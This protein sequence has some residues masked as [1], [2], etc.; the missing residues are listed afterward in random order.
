MVVRTSFAM[1]L[2]LGSLAAFA[3]DRTDGVASQQPVTQSAPTA[4]QP[5]TIDE[6]LTGASQYVIFPLAPAW[7]LRETWLGQNC[8][9]IDMKL[10]RLHRGGDGEA[11]AVVKRRASEIAQRWGYTHYSIARFSESIAAGWI[12]QRIASADVTFS[13]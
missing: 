5:G 9:R 2:F 13:H 8:V 7:S 1:V 6:L 4:R 11:Q 10:N 3:D 12:A